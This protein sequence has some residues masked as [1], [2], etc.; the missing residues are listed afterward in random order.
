MPSSV[1]VRVFYREWM[2]DFVRCF[3]YICWDDYMVFDFSFFNVVY[4]VDWFAYVEPSL[5]TWNESHLVVVYV[6][7]YMLLDLV[8]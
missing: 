6:L 8:G 7:F 1:I 4:D 2:L 3:F 5:W